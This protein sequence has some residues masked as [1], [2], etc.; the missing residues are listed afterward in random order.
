[1]ARLSLVRQGYDGNAPGR[2]E[3][4][5]GGET[6]F[7]RSSDRWFRLGRIYKNLS[8]PTNRLGKGLLHADIQGQKL[9]GDLLEELPFGFDRG[10]RMDHVSPL[11][12]IGEDLKPIW[13][14]F[15]TN[16]VPIPEQKSR[17]VHL[18]QEFIV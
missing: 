7:E 17:H 15:S 9:R 16:L 3:P 11:V 14:D 13:R 4:F 2:P 5:R 6:N 12:F 8:A 18:K 1:M 10:K